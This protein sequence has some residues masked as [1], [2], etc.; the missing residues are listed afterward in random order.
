MF[1]SSEWQIIAIFGLELF[2]KY[3]NRI[4]TMFMERSMVFNQ[5]SPT[6]STNVN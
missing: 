1:N 2:S 6:Y 4:P 3:V 5:H